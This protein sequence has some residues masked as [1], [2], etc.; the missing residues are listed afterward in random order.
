MAQLG[1]K[2]LND[3][4]G[5]EVGFTASRRPDGGMQIVFHDVS[6]KTLE[7]WRSFSLDHLENSD[8]LTTNLYDLRA[9]SQI[10]NEA[11]EF[12]VDVNSD[13]AVR[14]IRLAVVVADE[15]VRQAMQEVDA[16]SAGSGVEM[17]IFDNLEEAE[18]WLS[19]PLTLLV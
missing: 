14:N 15:Q 12:A 9:I 10:P 6:R 11:V 5:P 7:L 13:P 2:P 3:A 18:T 19:R 16:H 8:R 17:K 1:Q 4:P